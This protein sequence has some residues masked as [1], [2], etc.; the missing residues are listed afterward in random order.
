MKLFFLIFSIVLAVFLF[1][2]LIKVFKFFR[3]LICGN[4][5]G[6]KIK[7]SI[8]ET[9][10]KG[11]L[12]RYCKKYPYKAAFVQ[13]LILFL[14][15][16]KTT[17]LD[18][19]FIYK[20]SVVAI[21]NKHYK[22]KTKGARFSP[23]WNT[24]FV[25]KHSSLNA[26]IQNEGHIAALQRVLPTSYTFINCVYMSRGKASISG[27]LKNDVLGNSFKQM[28]ADIESKC[29]Y[30]YNKETITYAKN[31]LSKFKANKELEKQHVASVKARHGKA[32]IT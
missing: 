24:G 23:T 26:F 22:G 31:I 11:K 32:V 9:I 10:L 29:S 1:G 3:R 19:A 4:G 20:G 14:P 25:F 6:A 21:E 13:N 27:L 2:L 12:K 28:I 7:G 15:S 8:G 5:R 30:S 16:G 17:Q 18:F